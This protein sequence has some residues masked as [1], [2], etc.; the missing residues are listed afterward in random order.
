MPAT[1][2]T[3]ILFGIIFL[4]VL[5]ANQKR[6]IFA[7]PIEILREANVGEKEPKANV[8][9]TLL[10]IVCMVAGYSIA[11]MVREPLEALTMFFTAVILV[12]I[13]TYLLF[14]T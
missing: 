9:L 4:L 13:G 1:V 6:I 14:T 5:V 12:I 11:N 10:G 7:K 2:Y 3:L 8:I